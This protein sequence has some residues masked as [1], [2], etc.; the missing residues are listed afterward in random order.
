MKFGLLFALRNLD[1]KTKPQAEVYQEMMEQV[2]IAEEL[3]FDSVWMSEHHLVPDGYCPSVLVAAAAAAARTKTIKIGI[4]ILLLPLHDPLRVAEDAAVADLISD[5]RLILGMGI[6]Y[7]IDE[8]QAFG[9]DRHKRGSMMDEEVQ[10]IRKAWT[11]E[12][13]TFHGKHFHY[14]NVSMYPKPAQ[15]PH[16]PIWLAARGGK[17]IDRAAR[18]GDGFHGAGDAALFA[19]FVA[20]M[21]RHGRDPLSVP[22]AES[23]QCWVASTT[24]KAWEQ[25]GP[26]IRHTSGEYGAWYSEAADLPRDQLRRVVPNDPEAG[27][28]REGQTFVGTPDQVVG[29]FQELLERSPH[30][31][32]S[33]MHVPPGVPPKAVVEHLELFSKR[34]MPRFP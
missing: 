26:G 13:F 25:A 7:K 22:I 18:L 8:F 3:G 2:H 27:R 12:S 33:I 30:L 21:K 23:R 1:P 15:K 11:E 19:E 32:H 24:E 14:D 28:G 29:Q 17:A 34:V 4:R 16:P 20:A 6:G 10:I 31:T 9:K 5:G